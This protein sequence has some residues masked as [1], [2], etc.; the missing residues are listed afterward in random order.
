MCLF[1]DRRS[2]F[3]RFGEGLGIRSVVLGRDWGQDRWLVCRSA[4]VRTQT[5][6]TRATTSHRTDEK[7]KPTE[8][9]Q[10]KQ[11]YEKT[12]S[13]EKNKAKQA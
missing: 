12:K 6:A 4:L 1:G 8:K 3:G 7:A 10:A 13:T 2:V 9:D 11:A 5:T